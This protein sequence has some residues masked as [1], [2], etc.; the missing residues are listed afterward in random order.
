M[1]I[2]FCFGLLMSLKI[3]KRSDI[4]DSKWKEKNNTIFDTLRWLPIYVKTFL[5]D[6][7][8]YRFYAF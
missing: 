2:N 8:C 5:V 6:E 4:H 3:G 7:I 1:L